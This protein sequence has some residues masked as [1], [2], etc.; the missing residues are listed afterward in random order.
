MS[1][2]WRCTMRIWG[3]AGGWA[4]GLRRGNAERAVELCR[5][6][7]AVF[8]E[9]HDRLW[10]ANTL[11]VLGMAL[12]DRGAFSE[13]PAV[14]E[15]VP[16][17]LSRAEWQSSGSVGAQ[18]PWVTLRALGDYER[19]RASSSRVSPCWPPAD[20]PNHGRAVATLETVLGQATRSSGVTIELCRGAEEHRSGAG[21]DS[22]PQS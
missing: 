2:P 15:E 10:C 1:A 6:R 18:Q 17:A 8:C 13:A 3:C 16:G 14:L 19:A 12:M 11:N 5:E 21:A 4:S 7:L 22:N 20:M 9:L